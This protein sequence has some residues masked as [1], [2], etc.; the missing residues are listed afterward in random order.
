MHPLLYVL[1]GAV[2]CFIIGWLLGS[3]RPD[4]A[5]MLLRRVMELGQT[6]TYYAQAREMVEALG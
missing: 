4:E 5:R 3:R 6:C 1:L 2:P